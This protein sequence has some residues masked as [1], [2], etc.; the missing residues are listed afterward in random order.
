MNNVGG[1]GV[2]CVTL[3]PKLRNL[4]RSKNLK[5]YDSDFPQHRMSRLVHACE[6]SGL[7][8]FDP[9]ALWHKRLE[10]TS[11]RRTRF[12]T[13][14]TNHLHF[15]GHHSPSTVYEEI[16]DEFNTMSS[17]TVSRT[18][19]TDSIDEHL[20]GVDNLYLTIFLVKLLIL[21]L[22]AGIQAAFPLPLGTQIH[23]GGDR[24]QENKEDKVG[25]R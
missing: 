7:E 22:L 13:S 21:H 11:Y 1:L 9:Y 16:L 19:F 24:E 2:L 14:G 23:S 3:R 18:I 20:C 17:R 12:A 5:F 10:L 25:G 15:S 8:H 4:R 6:Q